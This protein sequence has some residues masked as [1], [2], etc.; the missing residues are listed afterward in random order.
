M[1]LPSARQT[2]AANRPQLSSADSS[3]ASNF[4]NVPLECR[5]ALSFRPRSNSSINRY[6]RLQAALDTKRSIRRPAI[7]PRI[8]EGHGGRSSL[9]QLMVPELL[10][11]GHDGVRAVRVAAV[12]VLL[13]RS[14][15]HLAGGSSRF[16]E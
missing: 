1:I 13:A 3:H 5:P 12:S 6:N 2:A 11:T 14:G 4:A 9:S 8:L 16:L 15:C 10:R 7:I